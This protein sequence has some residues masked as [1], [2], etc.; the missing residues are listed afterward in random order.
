MQPDCTWARGLDLTVE[1]DDVV[2]LQNPRRLG[3]AERFGAYYATLFGALTT[4]W[5]AAAT[6]AQQSCVRRTMTEVG[7]SLLRRQ[8][9]DKGSSVG[10]TLPG[11]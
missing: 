8:T 10:S 7:E 9:A 5:G 1:A 6:P 11:E 3:G 4:S 2:P